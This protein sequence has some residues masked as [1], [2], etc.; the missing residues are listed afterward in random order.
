MVI[1]RKVVG[2]QTHVGR[3]KRRDAL[4]PYARDA[5]VFPLPE[6][7]VMHENGVSRALAGGKNEIQTGA[8]ARDDAPHFL[9]AFDLKPIG[10]IV[11]KPFWR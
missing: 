7:A 4:A 3:Q 8:H 6:P 10:R 5:G 11:M 1:E 9:S 2:N